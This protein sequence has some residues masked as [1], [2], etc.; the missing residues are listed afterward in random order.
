M[1]FHSMKGIIA[2]DIDGTVTANS[3][4]LDLEVIDALSRLAEEGW[5][6]IFLTGRP[7]QWSFQTLK[8]LPFPFALAVQNG[9]ILLEMPSR[10]ILSRK[11]LTNAILPQMEAIC[12]D[13]KTDF[14]VYSGLENDDWCYYRPMHFPPPVLSYV[15]QRSAYLGEKWQSIEVFSNLPISLFSAVKFFVKEQKAFTLSQNIEKNLG[16]HAPPNRDPYNHDYFV[17]QATHPEATKGRVLKD[18]VQ[19]IEA[20]GPIIAAGDDHNDL[21]MLQVAH[22]K[23]VM[24][25]APSEL[26]DLADIIAP[27]AN[28]KGII[29]GL[30]EAVHRLTKQ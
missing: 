1:F 16:L 6:F 19:L 29:Q 9:A 30:T 12:Q 8:S 22:I 23:I 4:S 2:L 5:R 27:P 11:Y 18:F 14:V 26:L 24:A 17:I 10:K 25:N 7:F 20:S 13:Q 15:L 21:S 28:Q 3:H